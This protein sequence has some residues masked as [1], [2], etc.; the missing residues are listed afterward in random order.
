MVEP[1]VVESPRATF[2][3]RKSQE[4]TQNKEVAQRNAAA[5]AGIIEVYRSRMETLRFTDRDFG[6]LR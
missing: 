2:G 1:A 4:G 5:A 6:G 3:F